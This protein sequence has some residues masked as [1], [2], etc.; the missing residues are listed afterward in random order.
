MNSITEKCSMSVPLPLR[1]EEPTTVKAVEVALST[2]SPQTNTGLVSAKSANTIP[3]SSD[4]TV[5]DYPV[6]TKL[7]SF[8]TAAIN[9]RYPAKGRV[10]NTACEEIYYVISGSGTVHSGRGDAKLH[11]G[12]VYHFLKDELYSV[13][14]DKL[15]VAMMNV[16]PWTPAQ[17]KV[18][19]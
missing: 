13:D 18:S 2:L 12:D 16:P 17:H 11:Q 10:A 15:F 14:G 5:Y 6:A 19:E 3:V 8:G 4:C 9:G 1:N 7:F